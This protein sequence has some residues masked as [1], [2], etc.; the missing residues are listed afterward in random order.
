MQA[1]DKPVAVGVFTEYNI[2]LYA[3][4]ARDT[5]EEA[6]KAATRR[7]VQLP[8]VVVIKRPNEPPRKYRVQENGTITL[9]N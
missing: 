1:G 8:E 3:A 6:I 9:M 2:L 4:R 5:D 7:G